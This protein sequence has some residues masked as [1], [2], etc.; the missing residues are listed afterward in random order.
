MKSGCDCRWRAN[1][2]G[3]NS[4]STIAQANDF[5]ASYLTSVPQ[6]VVCKLSVTVISTSCVVV[7]I[8]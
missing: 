2:M 1:Y 3:L 8:K 5:C 7:R 6:C 4:Y